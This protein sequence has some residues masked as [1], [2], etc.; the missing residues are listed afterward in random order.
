MQHTH[1][2]TIKCIK[3]NWLFLKE[4]TLEGASFVEQVGNDTSVLF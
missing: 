3:G 1:T 4:A 2:H